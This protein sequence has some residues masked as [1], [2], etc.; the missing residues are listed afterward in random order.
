MRAVLVY[1]H[2]ILSEAVGAFLPGL[3]SPVTAIVLLVV[4]VALARGLWPSGWIGPSL[5]EDLQKALFL[6]ILL[7]VAS[8]IVSLIKAPFTLYQRQAAQIATLQAAQA[9]LATAIS[10]LQQT[11]NFIVTSPDQATAIAQSLAST[12]AVAPSTTALSEVGQGSDT[13]TTTSADSG[14]AEHP[15]GESN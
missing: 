1:T 3:S 15:G 14:E 13:E 5:W 7:V 12:Q 8:F 10:P 6:L 2:A 11:F 9:P 4:A